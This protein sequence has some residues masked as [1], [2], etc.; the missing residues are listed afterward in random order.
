MT[1]PQRRLRRGDPC[2]RPSRI[3]ALIKPTVRPLQTYMEPHL[4]TRATPPPAAS[5]PLDLVE[6]L[7]RVP[8]RIDAGGDAAIDA[9]L[10]QDFL[11][12]VLG[13]AVL[14]RAL[15]VQF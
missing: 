12:L 3:R 13:D 2:E 7:A 5:L 15:D 6:S 1:S 11:D 14:Q 9:D 10:K 8:E 4:V